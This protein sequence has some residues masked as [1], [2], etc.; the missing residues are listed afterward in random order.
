METTS[1][2]LGA[3]GIEAARLSETER[4]I[5]AFGVHSREVS[6]LVLKAF[7]SVYYV[8]KNGTDMEVGGTT[9]DPV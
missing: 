1:S 4:E 9:S 7:T 3:W 5:P 2:R 8:T 6:V